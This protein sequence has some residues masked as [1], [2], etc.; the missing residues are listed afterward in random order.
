MAS[1]RS[2][3]KLALVVKSGKVAEFIEIK[4][5]SVVFLK[6]KGHSSLEQKA[7]KCQ[8]ANEDVGNCHTSDG[9]DKLNNILRGQVVFNDFLYLQFMICMSQDF[10][11]EQSIK[12][13]S[14]QYNP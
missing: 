14:N 6:N 13:A 2:K 5:F 10:I 8:H 7:R 12:L 11:E 4:D 9:R 3:V 1:Q